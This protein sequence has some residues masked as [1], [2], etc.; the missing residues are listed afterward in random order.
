MAKLGTKKKPAI[1]RVQT[2]RKA[3]EL[4]LLCHQKGWEVIVGIEPD[5]PE[6]MTDV[7]QLLKAPAPVVITRPVKVS[8]NDYCPC[9]S[10]KKYRKCCLE[11]ESNIKEGPMPEESV[12]PPLSDFAHFWVPKIA[13][14]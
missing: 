3:Q 7:E 6:D 5:Q 8:R 10:G 13:G 9:G 14:T 1:V 12:S 2:E 11:K 4:L